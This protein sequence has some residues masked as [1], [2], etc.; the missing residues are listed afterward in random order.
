MHTEVSRAMSLHDHAQKAK[1]FDTAKKERTKAQAIQSLLPMLDRRDAQLRDWRRLPYVRAAKPLRGIVQ[2]TPTLT[3]EP[4]YRR[5]FKLFKSVQRDVRMIDLSHFDQQINVKQQWALYEMWVVLKLTHLF[6]S[7]LIDMGYERTS[8]SGL[9]RVI[10]DAFVAELDREYVVT[11]VS[12]ARTVRIAYERQY[13]S[14]KKALQSG[15]AF[16]ATTGSRKPDLVV[17]GYEHGK[18]DRIFVLDAKYKHTNGAVVLG[19]VVKIG[20][21][22]SEIAITDTNPK[23]T[24]AVRTGCAKAIG[25]IVFPGSEPFISPDD[26][27][28]GALPLVPGED[29][30]QRDVY[31]RLFTEWLT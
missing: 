12:G 31:T 22:L 25:R 27:L 5:L 10:D 14:R 20:Q 28:S 11:Y 4:R 3:N 13:V 29:V 16:H 1:W 7:I 23:R 2:P 24:V 8:A 18:P 21:Y 26:E 6:G 15:D 9:Y 30:V 19:D 17:E